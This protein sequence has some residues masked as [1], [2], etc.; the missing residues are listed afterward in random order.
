MSR[1]EEDLSWMR[2]ALTEAA[3][4]R[5]AVEPNPMVGAVVAREG[6]LL[7]LGHHARF[8]GPHAEVEALAA[9][10]DRA[11]G[12]TLYV[13][14]EPCNHHGKTPPCV[15]AILRAG[16]VRVVVA[17]RDPFPQVAGRG[18]ARLREAGL[19]VDVGPLAEAAA[20][21]NAPFLKRVFTG[22]PYVIAKWAMTLDGKTAVA[23]GDSRWISSPASRALVHEVRGRMDAIIVGVGTAIADDPQ[24]TARP[25]G[26]RV[27]VR[28]VL[29]GRARLPPSSRLA[30]T[31]RETPTLVAV[32]E[33][34]PE[35][36]HRE[37]RSLGCEV[38]A[39]PGTSRPSIAP[40]LEE[41]GRRGMTNVL[42]EG[43][44]LVLGA[45]FDAD[46]VDE[47]DV[48]LAPLIEGG[49]HARTP[50]R[51]RGRPLMGESVR[52]SRL[53]HSVVDGDARIRGTTP[54][55]WRSKLEALIERG[56]AGPT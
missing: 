35:D 50:V 27:P 25:P 54:R 5:G 30:A 1:D 38:V 13:T 55:S 21:L 22:L 6:A 11:R 4:G 40:L 52:L 43:G 31:A 56:E 48:F 15:D 23:I 33:A 46:E 53:E 39:F 42:V 49:D 51:G 8:G 29:D 45:F 24:L 26:P 18:L 34:A 7:G 37:L 36:R 9:A 14:L 17:H 12:S 47:V 10:G 32:A 20:L 2:L 3:K 19:Q 16:I 41:L 44:G 28:V